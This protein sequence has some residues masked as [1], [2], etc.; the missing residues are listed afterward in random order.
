M[1]KIKDIAIEMPM[2]LAEL[3]DCGLSDPTIQEYGQR[4]INCVSKFVS[5]EKLD[6]YVSS[7]RS[8]KVVAEKDTGVNATALVVGEGGNQSTQQ[9]TVPPAREKADM[10]LPESY[11]KKLLGTMM[12]LAQAWAQEVRSF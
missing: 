1:E 8:N 12:T 10:V 7:K 2:T 11:A 9:A 3:A 5:D 6:K 4:I